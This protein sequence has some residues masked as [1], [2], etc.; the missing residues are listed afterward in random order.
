MVPM[1][2]G[3]DDGLAALL[4][5]EIVQA[6]GV[7]SLVGD[8]LAGFHAGNEIAGGS[9]VVLLAGTQYKADRQAQGVYDGVD[10]GSKAA[11]RA[12]EGLSFRSPLLRRAPAA[13][14]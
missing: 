12:P 10:L 8:D 11:T 7:V 2:S 3:R 14:A 1:A 5:N 6:I 9:H 13:W 4:E